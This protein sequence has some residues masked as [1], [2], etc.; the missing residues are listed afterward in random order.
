MREC[1]HHRKP[2]GQIESWMCVV[3]SR[4]GV[5]VPDMSM[6]VSL[7]TALTSAEE[8]SWWLERVDGASPAA[9]TA[10]VLWLAEMLQHWAEVLAVEQ[11][12]EYSALATGLSEF[13]DTVLHQLKV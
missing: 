8:L 1:R 6:P 12:Q 5:T 9:D 13:A 3:D 4:G 11:A 10:W 2:R 7:Q